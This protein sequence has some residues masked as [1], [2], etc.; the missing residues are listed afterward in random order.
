VKFGVGLFPTGAAAETVRL[1]QLAEE[2]EFDCL[3]VSDTHMIWREAYVL[4]G[5]IAA[6]T[7]RIELAP[8]VTH[9][10]GRHPSVI[11]SALATLAELAPGRV[12]LGIGVGAS[13]PANIGEKAAPL[14]ELEQTITF[15]RQ[16][17]QGEPAVRADKQMRL[18]FAPGTA[19]PV[20]VAAASERTLEMSGRV[21]DGALIQGP[22]DRFDHSMAAVRQGQRAT[23]RSPET[24]SAVLWTACSVSPDGDE[25]REAVKPM[26]ARNAMVWLGRAARLG[27]L[28]PTD[29]EP[30]KRLQDEY[31]FSSHM[32]PKYSRLVEDRWVDRFAIAGSPQ[33]VEQRCRAALRT[34]PSQ[35]ALAFR[36]ADRARQMTL[37][38][39]E[40]MGP[41]RSV[42]C[43]PA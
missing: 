8:G 14:A 3:W 5:A 37:F 35:L 12:N 24:F 33:D 40:V 10:R 18:Q 13:G 16:L 25:A 17:L 27:Q 36:G 21:A 23:G 43:G 9:P 2:L 1:A 19:V 41:L 15:V 34:G 38:A 32:A 31:D 22:I 30:L 4:L 42:L 6:T 39:R 20:Y 26:V 11:A 28:D 7:R 29:L